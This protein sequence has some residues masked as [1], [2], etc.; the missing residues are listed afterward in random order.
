MSVEQNGYREIFNLQHH[1]SSEGA[2]R[3][4]P[5]LITVSKDQLDCDI[6]MPKRLVFSG[7]IDSS[8]FKNTV[9]EKPSSPGTWCVTASVA[10]HES[11]GQPSILLPSNPWANGADDLSAILSLL[12]G[13]HVQIGNGVEPYLPVVPGHA[14]ISKNFFRFNPVINWET[15]PALRDAGAGDAIEA[16]M[17]AMTHINVG[18]KIAMGSAALDGLNARWYKSNGTNRYTNEVKT[19]V[20]SA[21]QAFEAHMKTTG[22]SQELIDDMLPRLQNIAN[23]SALAKLTAFLKAVGMFPDAPNEEASKRLKWLNVLRNSV[24]HTGSIKLDIA[25]TPEQSLRIAAAVALLLQ[26]I[27]RIFIAK[28]LL[29]IADR[30]VIDAQMAVM[31]FFLNGTYNGQNILT[32]DYEAYRQRLISQHEEFGY[33][34]L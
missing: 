10:E 24:A 8:G 32:E 18:I 3:I 13:R 23:E 17:L 5:Y 15:L 33:F 2:F 11:L 22:V 4:G 19:S 26:D 34:D 28:T 16:V 20:R 7:T 27:C 1:F 29:K 9:K 6:A 31:T 12:T 30:G 25:D 21:A 14:I